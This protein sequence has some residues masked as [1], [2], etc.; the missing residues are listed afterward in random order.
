MTDMVQEPGTIG[1]ALVEFI[2]NDIMAED[3]AIDVTDS[4]D[5][6][7]VDSMGL[8]RILLFIEET[9]GFWIPDEDLTDDVVATSRSFAQYIHQKLGAS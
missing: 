6:A 9:Y 7:G 3:H 8:M 2:N 4:L 5:A 1:V